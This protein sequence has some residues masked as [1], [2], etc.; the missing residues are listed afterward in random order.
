MFSTEKQSLRFNK[1]GPPYG[2]R[3]TG[4]IIIIIIVIL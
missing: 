3:H 4:I 1:D 2:L